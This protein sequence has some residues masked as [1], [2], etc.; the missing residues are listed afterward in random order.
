MNDSPDTT[1]ANPGPEKP[2]RSRVRPPRPPRDA[3]IDDIRSRSNAAK[4]TRR[5]K[6]PDERYPQGRRAA[7]NRRRIIEAVTELWAEHGIAGDTFRVLALKAGVAPATIYNLTGNRD[8]TLNDIVTTHLVHL[9]ERLRIASD[10][11]AGAGAAER[12]EALLTAY[13]EGVANDRNTHFLLR[14]GLACMSRTAREQVR[15]RYRLLLER[16]GEPLTQLVPS[17]ESKVAVALAM[18]AAGAVA[19]APLWFDLTHELEVPATARRLTVMLL[20][21]VGSTEGLGP[22]PGC[23]G[24]A[25]ACA[26]AWVSGS[27]G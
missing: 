15:L 1:P 27:V 23:G 21:A 25:E 5:P 3:E 20:A 26:Q 17:V 6:L 14:H 7:N 8:E 16:L 19:D 12:L 13:L 2:A 24:P 22:W 18:A 4:R 9:N 11:T 10:L